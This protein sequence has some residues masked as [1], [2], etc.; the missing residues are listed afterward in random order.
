MAKLWTPAEVATRLRIHPSAVRRLS[1]DYEIGT[2]VNKRMRVYSEED[3]IVLQSHS[4]GK[5]G[6]PRK[7]SE[8][9][10][11][12]AALAEERAEQSIREGDPKAAELDLTMAQHL[13]RLAGHH[14]DS[15]NDP[16]QVH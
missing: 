12:S 9:L 13:R 4:T 8:S 1:A 2:K 5:A 3:V 15:S 16:E 10:T 7:L 6:R 11:T 14:R